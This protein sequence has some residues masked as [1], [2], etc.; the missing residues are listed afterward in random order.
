MTRTRCGT[1]KSNYV[2]LRN[3]DAT[4][5]KIFLRSCRALLSWKGTRFPGYQVGIS[6]CDNGNDD[7]STD[8]DTVGDNLIG[9]TLKADNDDRRAALLTATRAP[10]LHY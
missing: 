7:D 3:P 5:S 1:L 9:V 2:T 6:E 8:T 10:A 4:D